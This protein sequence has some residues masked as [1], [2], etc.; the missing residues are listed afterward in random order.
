MV[1][2]S[3]R[4]LRI[5]IMKPGLITIPENYDR[6]AVVNRCFNTKDIIPFMYFNGKAIVSDTTIKYKALTDVCIKSLADFFKEENYFKEVINPQDSLSNI[7]LSNN[8]INN[9][10]EVF[11]KTKSDICIFLD[12][13]NFFVFTPY[14]LSDVT[15]NMA[16]LSWRI[17]IKDGSLS[18]LYN[19]IDTL[20]YDPSDFPMTMD[21]QKRL[22]SIVDG[23]SNYLGRFA[24]SKIIPQWVPVERLYYKSNNQNMLLAEK[25]AFQNDWL[26]AAE[27]W[28]RLTNNKNQKIAAKAS[29]NMALACEM[30]GKHD[31]AID[32]LVKSFSI[33]KENDAVHKTN[34]QRYIA[35]LTQR[36]RE[37]QKLAK[38]VRNN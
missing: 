32:W 38:Q 15:S 6:I 4:T 8:S 35:V 28:N 33:L 7:L 1:L 18:Y 20:I 36:K 17:E 12:Y 23:S 34:C 2:D 22:Q 10:E 13:F 19:Q 30:E 24:G 9:P 25:Y 31:V 16:T 11:Q 37:L 5:E 26:K 21:A 27:L 14:G 29:Y 3:A